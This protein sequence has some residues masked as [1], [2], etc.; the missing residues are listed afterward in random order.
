MT[1]NKFNLDNDIIIPI[2]IFISK[3]CFLDEEK[4]NFDFD[5]KILLIYLLHLLILK[6]LFLKSIN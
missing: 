1:H 5:I 2:Q 3:N 6:N 4:N